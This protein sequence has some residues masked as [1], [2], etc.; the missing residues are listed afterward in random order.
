MR[1]RVDA[2]CDV[3]GLGSTLY[4]MVTGELPFGNVGPM[5]VCQKKIQGELPSAQARVPG[6]SARIDRTIRWAMVANR[7]KRL[8]SCLEFEQE[9]TD[10]RPTPFYGQQNG[11]GKSK[12]QELS[13]SGSTPAGVERLTWVILSIVALGALIAG[14][15]LFR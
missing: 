10:T 6:L 7:D 5:Q 8:A 9:L 13:S 3:Y 14:L 1:E 15:F 2:R 12:L 11:Y 4:T